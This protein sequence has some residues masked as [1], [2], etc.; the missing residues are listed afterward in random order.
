[1]FK[2]NS[3]Q[4]IRADLCFASILAFT[5]SSFLRSCLICQV[6]SEDAQQIA[7]DWDGIRLLLVFDEASTLIDQHYYNSFRWVFDNVLQIAWESGKSK[8][9]PQQ[10]LPFMAI[11]LGTNSR[12][13]DFTPPGEHASYRYFIRSMIVPRPFTSLAWDVHV[14]KPFQLRKRAAGLRSASLRYNHLPTM[15]WLCRFGRPVWYARWRSMFEK[16]DEDRLREKDRIIQLVQEKLCHIDCATVQDFKERMVTCTSGGG[17][18][19]TEDIIQASSAVLAVLVGLDFDFT[20]PSRAV[21]LVASRLRWA[22]ASNDTLTRFLTTYPSEPVLAD[23]ANELFFSELVPNM[24][25][26]YTG[27]LKVVLREIQ[28][29]NYDFGSEGELTARILCI[30]SLCQSDTQA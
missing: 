2:N 5:G 19:V 12:V 29:G 18:D 15:D 26:V 25:A 3:A 6:T 11:F 16:G 4:A 13:A 30:N 24:P 10:P 17:G 28:K 1:M 23:A 21:D 22:L 9:S 20:A 27:V 8:Y 14:G 7:C